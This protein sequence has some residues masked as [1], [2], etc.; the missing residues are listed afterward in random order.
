M[1]LVG[2]RHAG[3]STQLRSLFRDVRLHQEG[4]IP[5]A[6]THKKIRETFRISNE[7]GLYLRLT[8]PH[9]VGENITKF[10]DKTETKML[11]KTSRNSSFRWN[12]AGPL[13]PGA[14]KN[15]PHLN[16]AVEMFV[17]HFAPERTRVWIVN[18][19]AFGGWIDT[20][21]NF[22]GTANLDETV[23]KLRLIDGVEVA[24]LDAR[25]RDANGLLL[26]DFFDFT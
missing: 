1:F 11:N 17:S 5:R 7:R 20:T 3:K 14:N 15:M 24:F 23:E 19:N 12:F 8:S 10:L 13:Q 6:Q 4:K 2:N 16:T 9:E 21:A 25:D 18:P 22:A 26:A